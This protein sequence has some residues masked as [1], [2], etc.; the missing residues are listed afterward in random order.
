MG[1]EGKQGANEPNRTHPRHTKQ[2]TNTDGN[3][4][5][6]RTAAKERSPA[7]PR[8][9]NRQENHTG[10]T[11]PT[12]HP[13]QGRLKRARADAQLRATSPNTQHKTMHD[14]LESASMPT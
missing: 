13:K 3:Q 11:E 8:K 6:N 9:E 5:Q 10:S 1:R 2:Q 7:A 14:E 12:N 4:P